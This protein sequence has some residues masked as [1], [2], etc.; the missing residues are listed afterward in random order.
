M[1]NMQESLTV[2]TLKM[3]TKIT[4]NKKGQMQM[5]CSQCISSHITQLNKKT[6]SDLSSV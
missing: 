6:I 2:N 4:Q 5:M 1:I 3:L